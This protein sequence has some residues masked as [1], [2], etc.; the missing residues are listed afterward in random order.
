MT[1][2]PHLLSPAG[3]E[4]LARLMAGRPLLAFDLD[5]TLAPIVA[6]PQDARVPLPLARRL[7]RLG[8]RVP[9]AVVTGRRADDARLRLG[10]QPRCLIGSHGAEDDQDP[11]AAQRHRDELDGA[12]LGL[13]Q[14]AAQLDGAGIS[15]EDKGQSI[16]LHYRLAPDQALAEQVLDQV[17]Q[18]LA[19]SAPGLR[20]FGG[21]RVANLAGATAPDKAEAMWRLVARTGADRAFFAGDDVNDEPV[22]RAAPAHWL[23]LRVGHDHRNSSARYGVSGPAELLAVVDRLL[24]LSGA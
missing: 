10:F 4:A 1:A 23:T 3:D 16:A 7:E 2:I 14:L 11:V 17:L 18:Q 15:V 13:F 5:G 20:M 21:K 8:Q 22:F 6:R 19:Q 9:L 12:R 24:G